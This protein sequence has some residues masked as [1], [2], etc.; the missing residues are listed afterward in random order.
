MESKSITIES[1]IIDFCKQLELYIKSEHYKD[2]ISYGQFSTR[3]YDFFDQN[4]KA[5]EFIFMINIL[6]DEANTSHKLKEILE[7]IAY[8]DYDE[9]PGEFGASDYAKQKLI[10]LGIENNEQDYLGKI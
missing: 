7:K 5:K 10:E 8:L 4:E 9:I 1:T 2:K 3:F 6:K